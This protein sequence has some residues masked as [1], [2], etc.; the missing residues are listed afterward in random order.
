VGRT[1]TEGARAESIAAWSMRLDAVVASLIY[2]REW[3]L[4]Q[5]HINDLLS[6]ITQE[7][8]VVDQETDIFVL[9]NTPT[10][11]QKINMK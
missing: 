2:G 8:A 5:S 7:I 6:F 11:I 1:P 4:S 3:H 9:T 10:Y